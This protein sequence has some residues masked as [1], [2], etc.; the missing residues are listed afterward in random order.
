MALNYKLRF[1]SN[2]V[3][4]LTDGFIIGPPSFPSIEDWQ[5]YQN[6]L[7][8]GNTPEPA[9]PPP[10]YDVIVD[11]WQL[12]TIVAQDGLK[13]KMARAVSKGA[14]TDD[15]NPYYNIW[16]FGNTVKRQGQ[17]ASMMKKEL[18]LDDAQ[19]DDIF[20]RAEQLKELPPM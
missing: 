13:E 4:R 7:A 16:N 10:A 20:Q 1:N 12:R 2:L 17:F 6:W 9:D 3:V 19:L 11:V 15:T 8:D 5:E 18:N 14:T